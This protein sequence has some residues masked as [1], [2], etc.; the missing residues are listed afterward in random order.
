MNTPKEEYNVY[1]GYYMYTRDPIR[2]KVNMQIFG[3]HTDTTMYTLNDRDSVHT[4]T[5]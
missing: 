4:I 1:L 2:N 3:V 5:Y